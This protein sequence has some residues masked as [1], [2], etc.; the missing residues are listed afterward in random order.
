MN[1]YQKSIYELGEKV[2]NCPYFETGCKSELKSTSSFYQHGPE[3]SFVGSRYGEKNSV[4]VLFTR[5]NPIWP[6]NKGYFGSRESVVLF[7]REHG[8]L[9]NNN[10]ISLIFEHMVVGWTYQ[11][12]DF[13]GMQDAGTISGYKNQRLKSTDHQRENPLYGVRIIMNE[14]V[15][16][17]I[18][19][20]LVGNRT[21][22][23][24]CA[25]NNVIKCAGK[26]KSCNPTPVMEDLCDYYQRE[27]QILKPHVI[28]AMAN[29]TDDYIIDKVSKK[30]E[31][32]DDPLTYIK[33]NSDKILYWLTAHPLGLGRFKF[34]G[35]RIHKYKDLSKD[36]GFG[37]EFNEEERKRYS[38]GKKE[39]K[40]PDLFY[41]TLRLVQEV[42]KISDNIKN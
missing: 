18:F 34:K 39:E 33:L 37:R 30:E 8:D 6:E 3:M 13:W 38:V 24:Y 10:L 7:K 42:K 21:S 2:F 1:K 16:A 40:R 17:D 15:S 41:Y 28:V 4:R 25:I 22:L 26:G 11:K 20:N 9:A 35:S 27:L 19:P 14:M 29:P 36:I 23:D 32:E 5:L 31:N 12:F